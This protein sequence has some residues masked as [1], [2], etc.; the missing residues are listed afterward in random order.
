MKFKPIFD[1]Q[2]LDFKLAFYPYS[3]FIKDIMINQLM[4][5][6]NFKKF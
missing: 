2:Y 6:F 4:L 1:A 3:Y 5:F